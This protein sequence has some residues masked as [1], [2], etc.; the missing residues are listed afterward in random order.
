MG[1]DLTLFDRGT[2]DLVKACAKKANTTK[3]HLLYMN[4][5]PRPWGD[6]DKIVK[7]FEHAPYCLTQNHSDRA[8]AMMP[9]PLTKYYDDLLSSQFVLSPLGLETD[10][11]RTWEALAL[12]CIPIVEHNFIDPVFEGL[13][14]VFVHN[15]EEI[16]ERFLK[17]KYEQLKDLPHSD[18]IYFDYWN[19]QIKDAQRRIRNQDMQCARLETLCFDETDLSDLSDILQEYGADD[20]R[21]V[22]L[23][24]RGCLSGV[25]ALQLAS[26]M[27]FISRFCLH[28][29]WLDRGIWDNLEYYLI[30]HNLLM[31]RNKIDIADSEESF[32][33]MLNS[34][35]QKGTAVFLDL[36]YFRHALY[37]DINNYPHRLRHSLKRD[38][39][40]V[41]RQLKSEV[42]LCGNM[43]HDDYVKEVLAQLSQENA[44]AIKTKG[45]FWFLIVCE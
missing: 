38:I 32:N 30:D 26:E 21:R 37:W 2:E 22:N 12:G 24:Y 36:A 13:P 20:K 10:C 34:R 29:V 8:Y 39:Q 19:N 31:W 45:N 3:N 28:D 7:L 35:N 41:I 23:F 25:R 15:W 33:S 17:E 5:Y 14:V 43:R 40:N 6:R 1:Q 16:D 44:F 42:L 18:K 4:H 11:V 27:P 9:L